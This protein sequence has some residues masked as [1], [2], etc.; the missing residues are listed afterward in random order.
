MKLELPPY[1]SCVYLLT[2]SENHSLFEEY[3]IPEITSYFLS[4]MRLRLRAH[5]VYSAL[6][7]LFKATHAWDANDCVIHFIARQGPRE[8]RLR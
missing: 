6:A 8:S 3:T 5:N 7:F 2:C 4:R 1:L